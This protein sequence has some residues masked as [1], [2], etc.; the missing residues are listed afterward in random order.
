M[1]KSSN[2]ASKRPRSS[3]MSMPSAE[4]PRMGMPCWSKNSVRAM[5]VWPPKATT[6]PTGCST[7][8]TP[9]TSSGVRGSKYSRSAV[10]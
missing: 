7:S 2:R 6:T 9:I 5:A 4:V 10:S 8:I 1:P 3:A